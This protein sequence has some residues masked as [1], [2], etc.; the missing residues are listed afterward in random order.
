MPLLK[1]VV[2]FIVICFIMFQV[3]LFE[4][5]TRTGDL[6]LYLGVSSSFRKFKSRIVLGID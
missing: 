5:A 4:N 2:F 3:Y 6:D 1:R